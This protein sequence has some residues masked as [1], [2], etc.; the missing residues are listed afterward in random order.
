[1]L[2]EMDFKFMGAPGIF[3]VASSV[4]ILLVISLHYMLTRTKVGVAMRAVSEDTE[5]SSILG[6]DV[7][8]IQIV[9][10]F[11]TGGMA[12]LAGAMIPLW[13]ASSPSTGA[14]MI[15]SIMAASLLGGF[16][17]IYGAIIGGIGIGLSEILLTFFLQQ[18]IGMWV[19][20][21]RPLIPMIVLVIVLLVEPNG[22]Q[23]VWSRLVA[24]PTGERILNSLSRRKEE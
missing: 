6:I 18:R 20:E 11:L 2:K 14:F 21:Y 5:L 9:S 4:C 19:G 1:M 3:F 23:G 24:S 22:L 12:A 10:W 7:N 8:R 13:F 16:N 15:T 17:N